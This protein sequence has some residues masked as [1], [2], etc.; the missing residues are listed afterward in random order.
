MKTIQQKQKNWYNLFNIERTINKYNE[1]S[2]TGSLYF[3][4]TKFRS[5]L[6]V[7]YMFLCVPIFIQ[8]LRTYTWKEKRKHSDSKSVEKISTRGWFMVFNATFNNIAVISWRSVLSLEEIGG[9]GE[10]HRPFASHWQT[11]SHNVV[12]SSWTRFKLTTSVVIGT[13][14]TGSCK[15]NYHTITTTTAHH[16]EYFY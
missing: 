12:S 14:C 5:L 3:Y 4:E 9:P 2:F 10:N 6:L 13:D 15:S 16:K 1:Y 7:N 8:W 11:L